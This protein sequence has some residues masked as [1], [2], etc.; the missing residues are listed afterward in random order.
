MRTVVYARVSTDAQERDGTSLD[1][2]V[3]TCV[4]FADARGWTTVEI[5]RDA[6]SGF[7]LERRGLERL[8]GM[9]RRG[10]V[11]VVLAYAVDRLSRNQNHIGVLFDEV[12]S[13]GLRLEFA[14][15]TFEDT[16]VGRFILA[17]RAFVAEIER[18]KI[19]ERTMRGKLERARA[20]RLPQGTGR[21]IYG[22]RYNAATARREA[23][24][25]QATVVRRLFED[26]AGGASISGLTNSL[27]K[28]GIPTFLGKQWHTATVF[29]LLSNPAYAGNTLYR[30]TRA[31][32]V[33][34]PQTGRRRRHLSVRPR[35]EWVEVT[36][37]TDAIVSPE[38]WERVRQRLDDPERLR[39]GRRRSTYGLAG[40]VRCAACGRS[41]VGQTLSGN[42]RYYRCRAAFAGPKH[43]R[44][45]SRYV[46][47]DA[48]EQAVKA[49]IAEALAK[50]EIVLREIQR[51]ES[52]AETAPRVRDDSLQRL[53]D[54]RRL[55]LH[56]Y[57]CGE[58]DDGF[59]EEA[60][61]R[62][63]SE[64]DRIAKRPVP[65]RPNLPPQYDLEAVCE[66]ASSWL[67]EAAGD[68]V[69]LIAD[70]LAL[71]VRASPEGAEILGQLPAFTHHWTNIGITTCTY[72]G[73]AIPFSSTGR[74]TPCELGDVI[75]RTTEP[76]RTLSTS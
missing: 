73:S 39:M 50:P 35:E 25:S 27:N 58:V 61:A 70:A 30:R 65:A 43:E 72:P 22:Y 62:N 8:R 49:S 69:T 71:E 53:E 38:L 68:D 5:V 63:R 7:I 47:A 10:E 33:R 57:R 76:L 66:A 46:R 14:T 4:A 20:G 40:R 44:C 29:H 54:E 26:F 17:A 13:M 23:V 3:E 12:S 24:E 64:R 9:V 51:F 75:S 56:R 32:S 37:A 67:R 48:L 1:S 60:L 31:L 55:V 28:E 2:Q 45:Q 19:S 18:E 15:E 34:D 41:M 11:D 42:Y 16:A 59:L 52:A 36:G 21:G 74:K 6:A